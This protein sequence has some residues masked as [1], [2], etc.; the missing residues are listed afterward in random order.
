MIFTRLRALILSLLFLSR[1]SGQTIKVEVNV[2][3]VLCTVHDRQGK[4]ATNLK[5]EDFEIL[6]NGEPQPIRYF[7]RDTDLPLTIALLVDVSGSVNR[8]VQSEKA[9]AVRF[10]KEVLRPGDKAMLTGFSST[11]ALWRDFT[12]EVTELQAGLEEMH[13]IPFRGLPKDG[14]P[15][16]T[17]LLYDAVTSTE[18]NK[19]K[20]VAGRKTLVIISDGLDLGSRASLDMAVRAEQTTNTIV[21]SIC[22][23]N[24]HESGCFYL[25][26]LS[27]PT[28]G[29]V[30]DL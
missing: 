20:S 1:M 18:V 12:A 10:F 5:K 29:S 21:Y 26:S 22:Y 24:P 3:N 4:L 25:K 2:V 15:M 8:F 9:T 30:F 14:G 27:D 17:T 23:P 6:D 28:G 13:A 7:A 19:L 11:V 16:P